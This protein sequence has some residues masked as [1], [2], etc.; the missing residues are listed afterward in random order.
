MAYQIAA[1]YASFAVFGVLSFTLNSFCLLFGW[2][3]GLAGRERFFQYLVHRSFSAFVVW[4]ALVRIVPV[5]YEGF[6]RWPRRR[7]LVVAANHPGLMDVGWLLA[8]VPEGVCV[9]KPDVAR[10]VLYGSTARCA[11]Y[12]TTDRGHL[13]L[14]NAS[15]RLSQGHT[16]VVFPEGTRSPEGGMNPLK[17]GFIAMAR[18]AQ[19]P[20]QLVRIQCDSSL[21]AKERP[22]WV[23]PRLPANVTV[24]LGPCL[25]PPGR[26]TAAVME[27]IDAW[28][29]SAGKRCKEQPTPGR[30]VRSPA[31]T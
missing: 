28:F 9:T 5:R 17:P 23:V 14:R 27:S 24:T 22:W 16:V 15:R 6:A 26:D 8:R 31:P 3:P 21:L 29:L 7:G 20:I 18:L 10:N 19:V 12:L 30:S 25:P 1:Y 13:L 4:L 11:G 2:L